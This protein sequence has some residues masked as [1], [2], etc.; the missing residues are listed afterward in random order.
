V[1][2]RAVG[3]MPCR[4]GGPHN[5]WVAIT[6][7]CRGRLRERCRQCPAYGRALVIVVLAPTGSHRCTSTT[8]TGYGPGSE[9]SWRVCQR[10]TG[11]RCTPSSWIPCGRA[12]AALRCRHQLIAMAAGHGGA[13]GC[14]W[15]STWTSNPTEA[16]GARR[17]A[18]CQILR[19]R[20]SGRAHSS[21][22][23][24]NS[25]PSAALYDHGFL[26]H[27]RGP[28]R[29]PPTAASPGPPGRG[30]TRGCRVPRARPCGVRCMDLDETV[31]RP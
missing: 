9:A 14:E 7:E 6:D 29:L 15:C 17:D 12:G 31:I 2:R 11:R 16:P 23:T 19:S 28:A 30:H 13:P 25:A 18:A 3:R 22:L 20:R 8:L 5:R 21:V 1:T 27:G 4:W 26:D 24:I 10:G